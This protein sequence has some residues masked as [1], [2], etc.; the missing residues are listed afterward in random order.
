MPQSCGSV[1]SIRTRPEWALHGSAGLVGLRR[2]L[3]RTRPFA[4][5]LERKAESMVAG[6]AVHDGSTIGCRTFA[7]ERS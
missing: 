7:Q 3:R 6:A 4:P 1:I 5:A 2:S